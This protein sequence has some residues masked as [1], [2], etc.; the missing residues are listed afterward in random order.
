MVPGIYFITGSRIRERYIFNVM[1][2]NLIMNIKKLLLLITLISFIGTTI[3][4]IPLLI[5]YLRGVDPGS[6]LITQLHIIFGTIMILIVLIRI[7][8]NRKT[9]KAMLK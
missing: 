4:T 7:I 9:I 6:P 8:M 3:T 2:N 1:D 5:N